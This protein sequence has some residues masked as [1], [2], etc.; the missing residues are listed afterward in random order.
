MDDP[1]TQPGVVV[2]ADLCVQR[3]EGDRVVGSIE[4]QTQPDQ[5]V[6]VTS[7]GKLPS[8]SLR[9]VQ[10]ARR[11]LRLLAQTSQQSVT[12]QHEGRELLVV[13]HSSSG[14]STESIRW[15]S[16]LRTWM[17]QRFG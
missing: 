6:L 17:A 14:A 10:Q 15:W 2:D 11:A 3:I 12:V 8:G 5:S 4:V 9:Q 16:L 13:Q 1:P 7:T